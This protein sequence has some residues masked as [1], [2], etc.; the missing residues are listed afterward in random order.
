MNDRFNRFNKKDMEYFDYI[1]EHKKNLMLA[2][3]LM[4]NANEYGE[5]QG[6]SVSGMFIDY[7]EM[8][9]L[10][11]KILQHDLSKFSKEE[12]FNYRLK[13]FKDENDTEENIDFG[14]SLAWEHHYKNNEHHP[15][16][17]KDKE[18]MSGMAQ[19]E[20]M[21][22]W[23]AMSIK[24]K[25]DPFEYYKEKEYKLKEEYGDKLDYK[26]IYCGMSWLAA[27]LKCYFRRG[28][29]YNLHDSNW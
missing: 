28:K 23:T 24:F 18:K 8:D 16:N 6:G 4:C 19:L 14:F 9:I 13:F 2:Y 3:N 7:K 29:D 17:W 26:S 11:N 20:M 5:T 1:L 25:N 10:K 27:E 12:F 22:D 21:L 15:E